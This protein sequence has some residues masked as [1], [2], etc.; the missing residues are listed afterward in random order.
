LVALGERG[1]EVTVATWWKEPPPLGTSPLE[2]V[3]RNRIERAGLPAPWVNPNP[4]SKKPHEYRFSEGR[5]WRFDFAWP[6]RHVACEVEGGGWVGGR[7]VRGKGFAQ[8]LE[9]YN[10]AA[11]M[12]W[13]VIRVDGRMIEDGRAVKY[14]E[15]LL[16]SGADRPPE[17]A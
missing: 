13:V 15:S 9:K 3:L 8:D 2:L 4:N 11:M 12:G 14:L 17:P 16:K 6:D 7:H 1:K 10:A 5:Q